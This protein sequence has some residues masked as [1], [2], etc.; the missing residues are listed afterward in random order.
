MRV[1]KECRKREAD[2]YYDERKVSEAKA[3]GSRKEGGRGG[4][5][6]R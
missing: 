3:N 4:K 2:D 1:E 6:M 5:R